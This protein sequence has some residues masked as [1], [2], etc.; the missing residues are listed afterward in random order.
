MKAIIFDLDNTLT[1][2]MFF[3]KTACKRAL[4]AMISKGLP[5]TFDE[6]SKIF[7]ELYFKEGLED[8]EIFQKFLIKVNGFVDFKLLAYGI[9]AYREG[10][11]IISYD[12]VENVLKFLKTKYKLAIVSDAP[13]L[14][15]WIRLAHMKLDTYFDVILTS[16]DTGLLK[17]NPDVFLRAARELG[18]EPSECMMVGDN[19]ERDIGAKH[20]GMKTC[21][22]RY[23]SVFES[24]VKWDYEIDSIKELGEIL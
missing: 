14:K 24:K 18:V 6:A 11:E 4:M 21:F 19:P 1:D 15:A 17:P 9:V 16:E 3:K 8:K 2:F 12:G 10:R 22:A 7:Y 13:K 20:V 23:G 5:M